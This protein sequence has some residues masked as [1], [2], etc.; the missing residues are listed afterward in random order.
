MQ[1]AWEQPT[2]NSISTKHFL[3]STLLVL[4]EVFNG[5]YTLVLYY[6]KKIADL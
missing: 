1:S 6:Y 5:V 3:R 4:I 2:G